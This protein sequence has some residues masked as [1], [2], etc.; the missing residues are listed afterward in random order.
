MVGACEAH[1]SAREAIAKFAARRVACFDAFDLSGLC[2]FPFLQLTNLGLNMKHCDSRRPYHWL[3][4]FQALAILAVLALPFSALAGSM[5]VPFSSTAASC[6]IPQTDTTDKPFDPLVVADSF[7]G[8]QC[9]LETLSQTTTFY[10]YFSYPVAPSINIGRYFTTDLFDLNSDV[11]VK[12]ALYPFPPNPQ[13]Q[14]FAYYREEVTVSAGTD[15]YVGFA[16]PQPSSN[17]GSCY[18]GGATQYFFAG[19][20]ISTN[21]SITFN[22][23]T[24]SITKDMRYTNQYGVG[25]PC[26]ALPEPGTLTL[27]LLGIGTAGLLKLIGIRRRTQ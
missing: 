18:A 16:G 21:S 10:R 4:H 22:A 1:Q 2:P 7:A 8:Y 24:Q 5:E 17:I 23:P 9:T 26:N 25:D 12:L 15:L 27:M 14:N 11:I 20:N 13:F 19:A 6:D 3:S